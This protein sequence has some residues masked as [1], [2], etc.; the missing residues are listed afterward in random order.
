MPNEFRGS[1]DS[2]VFN[3]NV[4]SPSE[5]VITASDLDGKKYEVK[6]PWKK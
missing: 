4:V 6:A 3:P 5:I 1:R 2:A